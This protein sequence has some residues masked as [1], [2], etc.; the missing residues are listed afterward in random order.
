[1]G[2]FVVNKGTAAKVIKDNKTWIDD[3]NFTQITT[4][5]DLV[6]DKGELVID[7]TGVSKVALGPGQNKVIGG[8]YAK[9][10]YYG[11]ARKGWTIL[12]FHDSVIYG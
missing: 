2:M 3:N 10:G 7:P 9:A 5:K 4:T 6:F 11:F 1:M 8:Q 12:I